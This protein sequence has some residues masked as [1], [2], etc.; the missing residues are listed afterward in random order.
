MASIS[1]RTPTQILPANGQ[2][3]YRRLL[4]GLRADLDRGYLRPGDL[5]PPEVEIAR[6]H[7]I[8]R[9][10]V[11]QAIIELA[12][13]GWLKRERG[14]GTY[15]LKPRLARSLESIYSFAHETEGRGFA[16]E[17][18]ILHRAVRP[19]KAPMAE[20]L[21]LSPGAPVIEVELLRFVEGS[22][23]MLEFSVT[24]YERFPGLLR[25][26]LCQRSL[27]DLIAEQ[28]GA[29]VTLGREEIRPVVLD[30]RQAALLDL[31][32]GSPAFHVDREVLARHEPIELRRTL[33]RG[34]RYLY[35]VELPAAPR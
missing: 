4:E 5:L 12:R 2:P 32:P 19:A 7:G 28:L 6:R 23:L 1:A 8:S 24:S 17:T 26:D 30:R 22:P 21:E 15:V 35:R 31:A 3:L 33:I 25:A 16:H 11:R 27:Y 18:R 9:H 34:D 29:T 14:R 13:E 10:T 20:R